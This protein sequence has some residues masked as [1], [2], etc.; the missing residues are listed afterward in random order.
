MEYLSVPIGNVRNMTMKTQERLPR[1]NKNPVDL[2]GSYLESTF[3]LLQPSHSPHPQARGPGPWTQRHWP[4]IFM[5]VTNTASQK[6]NNRPVH[7]N[8]IMVTESVNIQRQIYF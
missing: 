2:T 6:Q 5:V 4:L 7:G 3:N 8:M 1:S